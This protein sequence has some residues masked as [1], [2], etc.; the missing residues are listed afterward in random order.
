[1]LRYARRFLAVWMIC[2]SWLGCF[3]IWITEP[4]GDVK[5]V[6]QSNKGRQ[7][8]ANRPVLTSK[9]SRQLQLW[10]DRKVNVY[11][12]TPFRFTCPHVPCE[13]S[14]VASINIST[15]EMSDGVLFFPKTSWDWDTMHLLRPRGHKWIFYSRDSPARTSPDVI[16]PKKY[17]NSSYDYIM[18][19]RR[20]YDFSVNFGS[21]DAGR[22]EVAADDV[23]RNWAENKTG[24]ITGPATDCQEASWQR[25]RLV[26]EL[27][28]LASVDMFGECGDTEICINTSDCR[29]K[30]TSHK[31]SLALENSRCQ[32]YI[33]EKFFFSLAMG[34][35][36]IVGGPPRA[37][38]ERVSPPNSF[39]HV[40]DFPSIQAL[41]DYI[42]II[43]GN[44]QLY[45]Q[46]FEWKKFGSIVNIKT[47]ESDLF[48]PENLC[49]IFERMHA[50]EVK[51]GKGIS[52]RHKMPEWEKWWTE[53]CVLD[54]GTY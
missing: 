42:K 6:D 22:P 39:I 31:F 40:N 50:D 29:A 24:L 11:S 47:R 12:A 51:E 18:T 30:M 38:Y 16:P 1:M 53:S 19:Y 26:K 17:Y 9:C 2:M 33:T 35:V 54:D 8:F 37:D 15:M 23:E 27:Q 7:F 46:F 10:T 25:A 52:T 34:T 43:D 45:N 21:Y 3:I 36:P 28:S 48:D 14:V 20:G 4:M 41:A 44:N 13:A 5:L 49:Q 32:D